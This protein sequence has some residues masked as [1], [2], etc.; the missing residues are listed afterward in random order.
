MSCLNI[1]LTKTRKI[2]ILVVGIVALIGLGV[3][4]YYQL[5]TYGYAKEVPVQL[6]YEEVQQ[7]WVLSSVISEKERFKMVLHAEDTEMVDG[8]TQAKAESEVG[9][10]FDPLLPYSE[11]NLEPTNLEWTRVW[12]IGRVPAYDIN[13]A[14]WL[15]TARYSVAVHKDGA[16]L[17]KRDVNINYKEQRVIKLDTPD[18]AVTIN[19]LGMLPQGVEVPSGDLA[20]I[21]DPSQK[22][23]IWNR[24]DLVNL[25]EWWNDGGYVHSS[26][27]WPWQDISWSDFWN[28]AR[29]Q[30]R[31]PS[32][33]NLVHVSDVTYIDDMDY[34]RLYYADIMFAGD[35]TV[36][37]PSELADTVI[38]NLFNPKP[39]ITQIDPSPLPEVYEGDDFSLAVT[40][41]NVG[42][43]GT[44]SVTIQSTGIAANPI[45]ETFAD[46]DEGMSLTFRWTIYALNVEEDSTRS[47]TITAQGRGGTVSETL[48]L[49]ILDKPG[50]TPP[51]PPEPPDS[52]P[53]SP[54]PAIPWE[55]LIVAAVGIVLVWLVWRRRK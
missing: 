54:S 15:T 27:R 18:G 45:T 23:H 28:T 9:L 13:D 38:V 10:L 53:P 29:E 48:E 55:L 49:R 51:D 39:L 11:T 33:V 50:Y 47:L 40:V 36:Y 5:S 4:P 30:G 22:E 2:L 52:V 17:S 6:G 46:F 42:T 44:M 1:R 20:V 21:L 43:E 41:K 37:I 8:E 31:L 24:L 34:V 12:E 25:V 19:N 35:V 14:G 32:D 7:Y 3:T 26:P 16:E